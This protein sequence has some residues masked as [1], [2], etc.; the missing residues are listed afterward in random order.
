MNSRLQLP[1]EAFQRELLRKAKRYKL[2]DALAE[3]RRFKGI[4]ADQQEIQKRA[5]TPQNNV[6][7]V[8]QPCGNCG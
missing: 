7:Q 8:A 5:N 4:L 2:T 1:I 6:D 3:G